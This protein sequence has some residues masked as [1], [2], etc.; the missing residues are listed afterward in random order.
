MVTG[1]IG[2]INYT[3]GNV[4]TYEWKIDLH[5]YATDNNKQAGSIAYIKFLLSRVQAGTSSGT[6]SRLWFD[7]FTLK[8]NFTDD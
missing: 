4:S 2:R 5:T 7:N 8:Y 3:I 6:D 1:G